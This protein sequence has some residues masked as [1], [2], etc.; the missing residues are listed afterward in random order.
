MSDEISDPL[1][2]LADVLKPDDRQPNLAQSLESVHAG[3][4]ALVLHER[5]PMGVRQLFETAKNARLYT[6]FVYRFHQV[7]EMLAY[8]ALE[9]ALKERWIAEIAGLPSID[10]LDVEFPG[11]SELLDMAV[12]RQWLR[13]E[14]FNSRHYRARMAL[15]SMRSHAAII[16]MQRSG[17]EILPIPEPTEA[18]IQECIVRFDVS[19]I[20]AEHIPDLRNQLAH[21]SARLSPT[22][23]LV[24][25]DVCDGIN[26]LF[27]GTAP[28]E[29]KDMRSEKP[30][31]LHGLFKKHLK[32]L[33]AKRRDL[34]G[35]EPFRHDTLPKGMP[36]RGVYLFSE[37]GRHLYVGRSNTIRK[38]IG[39]HS[40]PSAKHNMASFAFLLAKE[41]ANIGPATYRKGHGRAEILEQEHVKLAFASAKQRIRTMD[42]RFT[43]ETDP[44]RQTLLELYISVVHGT[45]YNDFDTH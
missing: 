6:Y 44:V 29:A 2:P 24:L 9:R 27:D 37:T 11:L 17:T 33:E 10:D 21:G 13:N 25:R 20:I 41:K 34:V 36:H 42:V 40:R 32:E 1:R 4:S 43:E 5:V 18:E 19:R 12:H 28:V 22:S 39:R 35:M 8:Q 26:M 14:G 31:G 3:L 30:P 23:D 16:E 38:R 45:P 15:M 7:A